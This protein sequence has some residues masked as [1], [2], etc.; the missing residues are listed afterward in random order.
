MIMLTLGQFVVSFSSPTVMLANFTLL[1][2]L[3]QWP[4]WVISAALNC[5]S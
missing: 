2:L 5:W 4:D 1:T 3:L